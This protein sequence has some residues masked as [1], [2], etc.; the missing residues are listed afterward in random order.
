MTYASINISQKFASFTEQWQP[1]I[2]AEMN[3]YRFRLVRPRGVPNTGD[4]TGERTAASE[5]WI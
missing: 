2:I 3:D 4:V 1:K 5:V